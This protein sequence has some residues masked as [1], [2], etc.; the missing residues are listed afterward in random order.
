MSVIRAKKDLYNNGKCFT[1]GKEYET[2]KTINNQRDLL[3]NARTIN[4]NGEPHYIG[5]WWK[6]FKIIK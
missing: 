5:L 4:D 1:K 3:D 2:T 6:H